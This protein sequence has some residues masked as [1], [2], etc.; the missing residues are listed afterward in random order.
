[1]NHRQLDLIYYQGDG[2][3]YSRQTTEIR[4]S[5]VIELLITAKVMNSRVFS[6]ISSCQF[7]QYTTLWLSAAA[8]IH[9]S[10][11]HD[12]QIKQSLFNVCDAL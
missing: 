6:I 5:P 11:F 10:K 12:R 1:M 4:K 8:V 7:L 9:L 3:F 2:L